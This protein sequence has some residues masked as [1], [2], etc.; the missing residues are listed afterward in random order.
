LI[1][2]TSTFWQLDPEVVPND[3]KSVLLQGQRMPFSRERPVSILSQ[4]AL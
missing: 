2:S 1:I 3:H 4:Q